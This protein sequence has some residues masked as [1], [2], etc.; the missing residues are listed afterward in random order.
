MNKIQL[1]VIKK[2]N[3]IE[4]WNEEKILTA[5]QKSATRFM[6]TL[7]KDQKEAILSFVYKEIDNKNYIPVD[8]EIRVPISD[9]HCFVEC[10]LDLVDKRVAESYRTYRDRKKNLEKIMQ[11]VSEER[12]RIYFSGDTENSNTDSDLVSS[13]RVL[14]LNVLNRSMYQQF[15]LSQQELTLMKTGMYHIHDMNARQDTMNCCLFDIANVLS[16]GF[17]LNGIRYTEPNSLDVAFDVIGDVVLSG[18]AQQYGGFTLPQIDFVLE[19]YGRKTFDKTYKKMYDKYIKAGVNDESAKNLADFDA[20]EQVKTELKQGF[21]GW[22]IKFNTVACSRGD[23]PFITVTSGLNNSEFGILCNTTMFE[24]HKNG[25]GEP[26]KKKPVLFP[27]YVYLYDEKIN[28][29]DTEVFKAALS[30][31]AKTMYPDWLS[32]SGEGY[33]SDMYKRYGKVISPMGCRAFLS[34]Y[35]IN[36]RLDPE[37][38]FVDHFY[39]AEDKED[40]PIF[41]GRFNNGAITINFPLIY[42][43]AKIRNVDFFDALDEIL[44][45]IRSIHKR[46]KD[47]L[48]EKKASINPLGFCQGGFWGFNLNPNQKLK[49]AKGWESVTYSFGVAALNELQRLYNGKSIAEDGEFCLEVMRHLNKK[50]E[51]FK[52]ED[53]ILY[54]IYGTPAESLCGKIVTQIRAFTKEHYFEITKKGYQVDIN[55]K[56][57]FIIPYVSDREYVS[58]SFHCHVTEDILPTK[59]Q[60]LE[61]RFWELCNGGKIQYVR[62]NVGYNI[63]AMK[64]L[65]VRAMKMGFYE[66]VN[67]ALSYCN[68]CGYEA[69][70]LDSR[71]DCPR[72]GGKDITKIDRMNGYLS[73]SRIKGKSRLNDAKMA[74]IADRK[75][76]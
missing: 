73:Y 20:W 14:V 72:C 53:H 28:G 70:D 34:P 42:L 24:V 31:S 12:D 3:S 8:E 2:D 39:P 46:T 51:E 33:I 32:M 61:H 40:T 74:E 68:D 75:S 10:A 71:C 55:E 17:E 47:Y 22:E 23:Y 44:E 7:T 35:Y 48:G 37:T 69:V 13:K 66:G 54:A 16:G 27:K 15:F 50:V 26:G 36:G 18:A 57:E 43:D 58:N 62:Y 6:I 45:T 38:G 65:I 29:P 59:K 64:S 52:K 25:Q 56:G 67:L 11:S 4:P 63:E 60:D 30:C 9:L 1:K 41:E 76:M 49:E 19:P 21:Q 5:C